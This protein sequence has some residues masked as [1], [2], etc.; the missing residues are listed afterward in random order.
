M[1]SRS[2]LCLAT[3]AFV[4]A[5]GQTAGMVSAQ[6][7]KTVINAATVPKYPPFEFKDPASG[8]LIGFDIDIV[9]AIAAKMGVK[10]NWID[11]SFD[12]LISSVETRR[13]DVIV[14]GMAD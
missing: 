14:A 8:K 9:D 5:F 4:V 10:V 13:A 7:S 2:R 1:L 12:Q 6:G 11:S 3:V